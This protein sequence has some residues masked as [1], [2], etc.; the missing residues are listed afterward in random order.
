MQ[1]QYGMFFKCIVSPIIDIRLKTQVYFSTIYF[2]KISKKNSVSICKNENQYSIQRGNPQSFRITPL[3][4]KI[5]RYVTKA[6]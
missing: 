1:L 4:S 5:C 3:F 6:F 2:P